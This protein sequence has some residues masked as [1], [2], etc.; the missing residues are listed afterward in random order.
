MMLPMGN[1]SR[2]GR[3]RHDGLVGTRESGPRPFELPDTFEPGARVPQL[4]RR[5]TRPWG[6]GQVDRH[7]GRILLALVVGVAVFVAIGLLR[8]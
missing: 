3:P 6:G 1:R 7:L 5:V 8:G 4:P 2:F